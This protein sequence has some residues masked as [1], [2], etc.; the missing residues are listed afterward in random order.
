MK[1]AMTITEATEVACAEVTAAGFTVESTHVRTEVVFA[2]S[3]ESSGFGVT[4][5]P[6]FTGSASFTPDPAA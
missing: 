5:A 1:Q 6:A 3:S 4:R 2:F